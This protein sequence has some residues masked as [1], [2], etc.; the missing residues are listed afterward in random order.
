MNIA[1]STS[2]DTTSKNAISYHLITK[3]DPGERGVG[4]QY[5][6]GLEKGFGRWS[7]GGRWYL[8]RL[9]VLR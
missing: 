5:G 2:S 7:K 3:R 1:V 6:A 9:Q 4:F 8:E